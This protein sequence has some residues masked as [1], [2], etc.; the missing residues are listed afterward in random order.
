M[1]TLF[2]KEVELFKN[3]ALEISDTQ[4]FVRTALIEVGFGTA[5]LFS[6]VDKNFDMVLG[7]ELSQ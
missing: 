4:N 6:K 1:G 7:V 5:E 3:L 2:Q